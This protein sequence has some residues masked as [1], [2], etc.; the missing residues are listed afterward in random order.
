MGAVTHQKGAFSP[1]E[2]GSIHLRSDEVV[3]RK[4]Y[5]GNK[6]TLLWGLFSYTDY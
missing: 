5:S 4:H 1:V 6:T 2:V 3:D